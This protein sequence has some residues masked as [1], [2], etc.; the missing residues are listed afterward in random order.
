MMRGK[1]TNKIFHICVSILV[2]IGCEAQ[3][4]QEMKMRSDLQTHYSLISEGKTGS[5]R[6][7]LRQFMDAEGET[8]Q[9]LFLMGLSY[10]HE[11]KYTKAIQWF[12]RAAVF[13]EP[14]QRYPPAWHFLGWSYY[15]LGNVA[16][17]KLAFEKYLILDPGEGD[18]LFGLGLLAMDE[19]FFD[20]AARLF[21]QSIVEQPD[22]QSGRAK[23]KARLADIFT[24]KGLW[25]EA[26]S[27]Y[28]EALQLDQD[29]YEVWY[30]LA[31][32]LRRIQ[33]D[34]ESEEALR[35]FEVTKQRVRPEL[36]ST[37]FPE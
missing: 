16:E 2:F 9:P 15:Y 32:A 26:V 5:A 25:N 13:D 14:S 29:L 22:R 19:G 31:M 24:E 37:R 21:E 36:S 18:S 33:R 7:R 11:R 6:V 27:L 10:H 20:K 34:Q 17:S 1:Y 8:A 30:H 3:T 4:P 23:S 28:K 35:M 12:K